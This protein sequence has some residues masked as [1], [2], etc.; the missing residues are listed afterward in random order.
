MRKKKVR[1]K[2]LFGLLLLLP[3]TVF[4]TFTMLI[5]TVWNFVLSFATWSPL[6]DFKFVGLDNYIRFLSDP[7]TLDSFKHSIFIAVVSAVIAIMFGLLLALLIYR[8]TN[9]EG[10]FFRL[11]FFMPAMMPFV[12]IG[13]LFTFLLSPNMG[14]IN[15]ILE[16]FGLGNLTRAWLAEPGLVLWTLAIVSGWRGAG[17]V[18]MLSYASIVKIPSSMFEAAVLEGAGFFRQVRMIILPLIKPT[19]QLVS[20]LTLIGAFKTYDF[21]YTMTK[22]GPGN[23]STIVPI[24]MLDMGFQHNQFGYAAAIGVVFTLLVAVIIFVS[25]RLMKGDIYEY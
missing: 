7:I 10:T 9:K 25:Q 2:T 23:Y 6:T 1:P 4:I 12:V 3:A 17:S 13:M 11:V 8:V 5:P 24:H 19:I 14:L 21:V 20:M 15:Q 22:G 18:M 16:L